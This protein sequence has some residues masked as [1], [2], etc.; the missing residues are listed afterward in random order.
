MC[1]WD[2]DILV[3]ITLSPCSFFRCPRRFRICETCELNGSW[4]GLCFTIIIA[5][6]QRT[7]QTS[8][9]TP[10]CFIIALRTDIDI[11]SDSS[12]TFLGWP[13]SNTADLIINDEHCSAGNS[14]ATGVRTTIINDVESSHMCFGVFGHLSRSF[15]VNLRVAIRISAIRYTSR[16]PVTLSLPSCCTSSTGKGMYVILPLSID[17]GILRN[18]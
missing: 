15:D 11:L 16:I 10:T 5:H 1:K 4:V 8:L 3:Y 18:G 6:N 12:Q 14:Q 2:T 13:I 9:L 17:S 7:I